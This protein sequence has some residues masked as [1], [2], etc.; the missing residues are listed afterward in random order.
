[1]RMRIPHAAAA[2]CSLLAAAPASAF[3]PPAP[4]A[5]GG[6]QLR[7]YTTLADQLASLSYDGS[8]AGKAAA[9]KASAAAAVAG[10]AAAAKAAAAGK[11]AAAA[12]TAAAA[13][14]ASAAT[15]GGPSI[16]DA[17]P[18]LS[19]I[20]GK[21]T[22]S[23]VLTSVSSLAELSD[24]ISAMVQTYEA[25]ADDKLTNSAVGDAWLSAKEQ[26]GPLFNALIHPD[27]PPSVTLLIASYV[28]YSVV[29]TVLSFGDEPPPNSPYPMNKYDPVSARRY[30]DGKW[31]L[32]VSR[33]VQVAFL[34]GTFLSGLAL[35]YLSGKLEANS[36]VRAE[37][38]SVLLTKLGP[39]F[40][41]IG[42]SLSIRTDLLSP[43]YVRG[44]K[45]L[46][47]QV[48]PFSTAEAREI[49]ESELGSRIEDVFEDFPKE[50]I[51]AA[52]LGQ[53][54][55]AT[56]RG[57]ANGDGEDGERDVAV[58][59]QRPNI[60]NQIAL[61]MHLIRE[62]AP[63]LK[64]T[65]NLN[66]DF[67]GVVDTWGAGFVDEL[68]YIE[69]AI[70]AQSFTES[71]TQTPLSGVVFAPPVVNEL[72]T[73]KVL[74]TEWVVGERLDKSAKEDVSILCSIAMNSYLT[75]MLETG[76]L[77]CDPHPGNL[78]RTTDG[79]LCILDWGM[80]TR[81]DPDL[82]ITLIEHMAHLTSAD[83]EEIPK[84]LLLL[85]FIPEDKSDLIRDSGVVE[86][87]AEIYGAWTAGGGAAAVN[88]NKVVADLQDLTAEKG[89][90]F[91]I[92]PYFA[93]IAKSFSVLEGIGLSND[94]KYSIIN[95][96]LPY[97]SKRL[98]TD[99]SE[100]TGGAL[101]TF[102]FGPDKS[103]ENR[104]IDYD[105]VE[106]LVTGFGSYTTSASGELLGKNATRAEIIEGVAEQVLDLLATEE[107]TPLQQIFIEQLAKIITST[108]RSVWSQLRE[109]SGVLPSGRTV[110]G[111][112]VDPLG[113]FRT[114]PVV[115]PNE[116][117]ERTVE[118]T[119]NLIQLLTETTAQSESNIDIST[120]SNA[121]VVEIS[122]IIAQ[123]LFE[124]R[125]GVFKTTNRLAMQ[126]LQLTADR[127]EQGGE[128][129]IVVVN[130]P[131]IK[132][133]S[134]GRIHE[135]SRTEDTKK[136]SDRLESARQILA[137]IEQ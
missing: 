31:G 43:A 96:C 49:I 61:D 36:Q 7:A 77:H 89:N 99:K 88:V 73:R 8:F 33:A 3:L 119:R 30:F 24:A 81:L 65:F 34:S 78:L 111:T 122:G 67:V 46:Q 85:G 66:T 92:P 116:L 84:D 58:K 11:A 128:R 125:S 98:L 39:S 1:M 124:R 45:S 37:E 102:I 75:M 72:T 112:L 76:T 20:V 109:S 51:A 53:V 23:P 117:D 86:T 69:E 100:R 126:L 5:A 2:A 114:S 22:S 17:L 133:G 87:L 113:I 115:R 25:L 19:G 97:V 134:D 105:R 136:A 95:E 103:N 32:V 29:S 118:T 27:L 121:E 12:K 131:G 90:L 71:I 21:L 13:T 10:K 137:T 110:L 56:I 54:Y 132:E 52:S 42:Q 129:D 135:E 123:K 83:Y 41:K 82:Q 35:D 104:I 94:A 63:V 26:L 48:P 40:I 15:V 62:V 47:D 50:P 108:T 80:V 91:Q 70:N 55:K 57:A 16:L 60:Q 9:G 18:D 44:L 101:S 28:T 130:E 14:A 74:T 4:R 59:V 120:L 106:Q 6:T 93:Y 107:E 38:L 127:L 68:D 79:K 64:R